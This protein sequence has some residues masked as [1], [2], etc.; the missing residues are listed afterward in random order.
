[1][2]FSFFIKVRYRWVFLL[3]FVK[4]P[5]GDIRICIDM[6]IPN[7]AIKR[8]H[9]PMPTLNETPEK[10]ERANINEATIKLF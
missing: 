9:H 8:V 2:S 4:K 6:Q 3:S 5:D 7:T 10:L 1:M